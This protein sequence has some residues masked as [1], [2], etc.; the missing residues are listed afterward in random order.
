[1]AKDSIK[2]QT[3]DYPGINPVILNT[4]VKKSRRGKRSDDFRTRFLNN[5]LDKKQE[6]EDTIDYLISGQKE[7]IG[8]SSSDN[9]INFIFT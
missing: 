5:L 8:K 9:Y 7:D 3:S 1:M 2:D 6:L 4:K